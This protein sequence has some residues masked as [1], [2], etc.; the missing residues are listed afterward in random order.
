MVLA[1]A[2]AAVFPATGAP[3][4]PVTG[5]CLEA[6]G[7]DFFPGQLDPLVRNGV[8]WISLTPFGW[9]RSLHDPHL[10]F[11]PGVEHVIWGE[12][13]EGLAAIVRAAHQRGLAVLLSPHVW[14]HAA[15]DGRW[16]ADIEMN[17]EADWRS[18]FRDY[19]RFIL[20][21]AKLAETLDVEMLSVG[22]E[23]RQA[24]VTREADWRTLIAGVRGA[25]RGLLTYSANWFEE[26]EKIRFW[27]ALDYIG[28]QAYFPLGQ[29][30]TLADLKKA[31]TQPLRRLHALSSRAGK[32]ILFTE[33]GYKSAQGATEE[34]W[35]WRPRG[36][37][38][39]ELQARAYRALLET[40]QGR[41]WFA[42]LFLWK[43]H[44]GGGGSAASGRGFSP[45]G[46]PA[47]RVMRES[48]L[49][50]PR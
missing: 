46:K 11:S 36:T 34:P 6:P 48:F 3:V 10:T 2:V 39:P 30:R 9:Q 42:G 44:L 33:V 28:V 43:W 50:G 4:P 23:L 8:R 16:R 18:W 13:D 29:G 20:H 14:L 37:P 22:L 45:Q 41:P 15:G 5:V 31:W 38:D 7:P 19:R 24:A 26:P 35:R 32:P 40:F 1:A 49:P 25:Y 12:S 27:D 17:S 21:Y 47:L